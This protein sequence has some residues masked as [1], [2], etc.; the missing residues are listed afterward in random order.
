MA[1]YAHNSR[2]GLDQ[3]PAYSLLE[4]VVG[5]GGQEGA[6]ELQQLLLG[7]KGS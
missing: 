7:Q 5:Q 6:E 2:H 3:N 1:W 4:Q